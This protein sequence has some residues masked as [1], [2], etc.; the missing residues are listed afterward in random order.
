MPNLNL[1]TS[2]VISRKNCKDLKTIIYLVTNIIIYIHV[3]MR[4]IQVMHF[5]FQYP[6]NKSYC[7]PE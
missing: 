1:N 6:Y 5:W 2:L 4:T 7:E 3:V